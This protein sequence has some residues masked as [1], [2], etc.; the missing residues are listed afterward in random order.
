M[1][2][3]WSDDECAPEDADD[4]VEPNNHDSDDDD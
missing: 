3:G 4:G 2:E 1:P